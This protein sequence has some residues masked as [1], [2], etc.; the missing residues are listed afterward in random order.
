VFLDDVN[1]ALKMDVSFVKTGKKQRRRSG[2]ARELFRI[3]SRI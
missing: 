1:A 2:L 3:D